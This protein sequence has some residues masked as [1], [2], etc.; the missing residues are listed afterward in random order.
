MG[1]IQ[2][3]RRNLMK[4]IRKGILLLLFCVFTLAMFSFA[5]ACGGGK[6]IKVSFDSD[7]ADSEVPSQTVD[8]G[9]EI[10]LP[11]PTKDG[12]VFDGW[13]DNAAKTG[14]VYK[15]STTVNADTTF[16]AKWT[17][18]YNLTLDFD[19][20]DYGGESSITFMVGV[21]K[22]LLDA[23]WKGTAL[24]DIQPAKDDVEFGAW[25]DENDNEINE[26]SVMPGRDCTIKAKYKVYYTIEVHTQTEPHGTEYE[27]DESNYIN[28]MGY[29]DELLS[30]NAPQIE[31]YEFNSQHEGNITALTLQK[32]ASANKFVLFYDRASY[33]VIYNANKPADAEVEGEMRDTVYVY[34]EEGIVANSKFTVE[35]YRLAGWA[36]S[37]TGSVVY[38]SGNKLEDGNYNLYA[39]WDKGYRDIL[40]GT[41][42]IYF[43]RTYEGRVILLR[44]GFEFNGTRKSLNSDG[45]YVEDENG[46]YI[47][48]GNKL[49]A[50]LDQKNMTFVFFYSDR[51]GTYEHVVTYDNAT[52]ADKIDATLQLDGFETGKLTENGTTK[53][54]TYYYD[55]ETGRFMLTVS[56]EKDPRGFVFGLKDGK[57]VFTFLGSEVGEYLMYQ[58]TGITS[59]MPMTTSILLD[60]VGGVSICDAETGD[61]IMSGVYHKPTTV[62]SG[63]KTVYPYVDSIIDGRHWEV[64]LTSFSASGAT[65]PGAILKDTDVA[66]TFT[67]E[68]EDGKTETL[69]I[70][71]FN[72]YNGAAEY[73]VDG[74]TEKYDYYTETSPLGPVLHLLTNN[75]TEQ[76][77]EYKIFMLGTEYNS[78]G[79]LKDNCKF[80]D[81]RKFTQYYWLF[82]SN[83]QNSYTEAVSL[84]VFDGEDDKK[85]FK[86]TVAEPQN[87]EMVNVEYTL[88]GYEAMIFTT[89]G[90]I[91]GYVTEGE[92]A[93][94]CCSQLKSYNIKANPFF[95][96]EAHI[97][98]EELETLKDDEDFM[99]GHSYKGFYTT[100]EFQTLE[101]NIGDAFYIYLSL[102]NYSHTKYWNY[103]IYSTLAEDGNFQ[104][105]VTITYNVLATVRGSGFEGYSAYYWSDANTYI[106]GSVEEVITD[107][108]ASAKNFFRNA[109]QYYTF[110][111]Y[112][113]SGSTLLEKYFGYFTDKDE[114]DNLRAYIE[115]FEHS[116]RSMNRIRT[117]TRRV[118]AITLTDSYM[119]MH[120]A[121]DGKTAY[122]Y[123]TQS[124]YRAGDVIAGTYTEVSRTQ[125][126]AIKYLFTPND[127]S[128]IKPFE[129]IW[130]SRLSQWGDSYVD[131]FRLCDDR[132]KDF[133][134]TLSDGSTIT[135]DGFGHYARFEAKDGTVIEGNYIFFTDADD[136][137]TQ[138]AIYTNNQTSIYLQV[139]IATDEQGNFLD[140]KLEERAD[141]YLF[142][143][144]DNW[145]PSGFD[146]AIIVF[147]SKDHTF[148]MPLYGAWDWYVDYENGIVHDDLW[149]PNDYFLS[150]YAEGTY[151]LLDEDEALFALHCEMKKNGIKTGETRDFVVRMMFGSNDSCVVVQDDAIMGSYVSPDNEVIYIDG[152]GKAFFVDGFGNRREGGYT[153]IGSNPA[154]N[155]FHYVSFEDGKESVVAI[156][157]QA[158]KTFEIGNKP[159]NRATFYSDEFDAV[160]FGDVLYVDGNGIGYWFLD[161]SDNY[162]YKLYMAGY[163]EELGYLWTLDTS[164]Y[165]FPNKED[166][167]YVLNGKVYT[168]YQEGTSYSFEGS[169]VFD[170]FLN[171]EKQKNNAKWDGMKLEFTPDGSDAMNAPVTFTFNHNGETK[172]Y[173]EYTLR[174]EFISVLQQKVVTSLKLFQKNNP[175]GYRLELNRNA[176]GKTGT[177]V[178]HAAATEIEWADYNVDVRGGIS[179]VKM[180]SGKNYTIGVRSW[181]ISDWGI[182]D[183]NEEIVSLV[184]NAT[185]K[186]GKILTTDF[187]YSKAFDEKKGAH[188]ITE[189]KNIN[190]KNGIPAYEITFKGTDDNT[191]SAWMEMLEVRQDGRSRVYF[192]LFALNVKV[193]F[194]TYLGDISTLHNGDKAEPHTSGQKVRVTVQQFE[195]AYW[196][197]L[198]YGSVYTISISKV[199]EDGT[200]K[201]EDSLI[202]EESLGNWVEDLIIIFTHDKNDDEQKSP[203]EKQKPAYVI[204]VTR[205][206]NNI[207][208]NARIDT[209]EYYVVKSDEK[210]KKEITDDDGD[211]TEGSGEEYEAWVFGFAK[212]YGRAS[213]D[214]Q[215]SLKEY[216]CYA[217][218]FNTQKGVYEQVTFYGQVVYNAAN[219]TY[220]LNYTLNGEASSSRVML[221]VKRDSSGKITSVT[222]A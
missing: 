44:A 5:V 143:A 173:T 122:Y 45:N 222:T 47:D 19:Q 33:R 46:I 113:N 63:D 161:P 41:D 215:D 171:D 130:E 194:D 22:S 147:N 121:T 60:G 124:A 72:G 192:L 93:L 64:Y 81:Y 30:L 71:G 132:W 102:N 58:R 163:D 148:T 57:Q 149:D 83:G 74:N 138:F 123:P 55:T 31:H 11:T 51:V 175:Y 78:D 69:K 77:A 165:K 159:E 82:E 128:A 21:G 152:F 32:S 103:T 221:Q 73:T 48:F 34:G 109:D 199:G 75:P 105:C 66:G 90:S 168:R 144:S 116:P 28:E 115:F 1:I 25:F 176:D 9:A 153:F 157:D 214:S 155:N 37:A 12:Y 125:F 178:L 139:A 162:N 203:A 67:R 193:E 180:T 216:L 100:F 2:F 6:Q 205:D 154:D 145:F 190:M 62:G 185:D 212:G 92:D 70:S 206:E 56:G 40:G 140:L 200:V 104:E 85:E 99:Y 164:T 39:I 151:E 202:T 135:L 20:G 183:P 133:S 170:A 80:T 24:K 218:K 184:F 65:I 158:K 142:F 179:Y 42:Y 169:I 54:C 213:A 87:G 207:I 204:K 141:Y 107:T 111:Y 150:M 211:A 4:A 101:L 129:F 220:I 96:F 49:L 191:Y 86:E 17:R 95:H 53:D 94:K 91:P 188:K 137:Y 13:Y 50:K 182:D 174:K 177:F 108:G 16:Y 209:S 118:G 84:V 26:T 120:F 210:V 160:E 79:T 61:P 43:P 7:G 88:H 217:A 38:Q 97:P 23:R 187:L 219:D 15:N 127:L 201:E 136:K 189:D 119:G 114:D 18:G 106:Q 59:Y 52:D 112:D 197:A 89:E 196:G 10:I 8:V 98:E 166:D 29:V 167:Q 156:F 172:V 131:Q 198:E 110:F 181:P 195:C 186:K 35:G 134:R 3:L 126:N 146:Q 36:T 76:Q 117:V 68:T 27:I 14:T 208:T